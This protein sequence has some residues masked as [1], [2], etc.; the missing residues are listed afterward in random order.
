[1]GIRAYA[2]P[3]SPPAN[4]ASHIPPAIPAPPLP[5]P[6]LTLISRRTRSSLPQSYWRCAGSVCRGQDVGR[7]R[8]WMTLLR[9]QSS[10]PDNQ[11]PPCQVKRTHTLGGVKCKSLILDTHS[12]IFICISVNTLYNMSII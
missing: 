4:P 12:C 5:S 7:Q 9:S 11:N 10:C 2:L 6:P 1:M 8:K 3:Y